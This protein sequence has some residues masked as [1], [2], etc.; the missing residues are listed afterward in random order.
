MSEKL[1]FSQNLRLNLKLPF[2]S[3]S[4][5]QKTVETF[6]REGEEIINISTLI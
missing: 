6:H 2:F 5:S 4:H 1:I 3:K